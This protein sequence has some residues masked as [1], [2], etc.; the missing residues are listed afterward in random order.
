M[1]ENEPDDTTEASATAKQEG[2]HWTM[3]LLLWI[4]EIIGGMVRGVA[5]CFAFLLELF[6]AAG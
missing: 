5:W 4:P 6:S 2:L 1:S 3:D